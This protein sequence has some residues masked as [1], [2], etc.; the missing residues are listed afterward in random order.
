MMDAKHHG[1]I[2]EIIREAA[3]IHEAMPHINFT[4]WV[5][6]DTFCIIKGIYE[7]KR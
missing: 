6:C 2:P 5:W 3:C 7:K 4:Y 1:N